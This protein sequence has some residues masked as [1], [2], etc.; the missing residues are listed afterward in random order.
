MRIPALIIIALCGAVGVDAQDLR[1]TITLGAGTAPAVGVIVE[2]TPVA[3]GAPVARTLTNGQGYFAIRL[4]ADVPVTV[5]ALRIGNRPTPLGTF[6]LA[7]G[8]QRSER[9][10]LTGA[11]VVL[12]RV[13]VV[14]ER[15]CR[16]DGEDA[17]ELLTLFDEAR[18][19]ITSTQLAGAT[20]RMTAEWSVQTQVASLRGVALGEPTVR[21]FRAPS[22]SPFVSISPDSLA[23]VGYLEADGETWTYHAPDARV[24][25][26]D[27]FV[28]QNCFRAVPWE[29]DST[30]DWVGISFAPAGRPARGRVRIAG[31]L[32]IDRPTAELRR[33][34]YEYVSLPREITGTPAGGTVEFLRL[35]TGAWLV[36]R[37][38]IRMPR[39][40]TYVDHGVAGLNIGGGTRSTQTTRTT[41]ITSMEV[42]SG[43]ILEVRRA[44][45]VVYRAE[46]EAARAGANANVA[47]LC[48]APDGAPQ[49]MLWGTLRTAGGAPIADAHV[50]AEWQ[51]GHRYYSALNRE[52][53]TARRATR[54][55]ANG[56]WF[57]C[58]VPTDR[59][60]QLTHDL[61]AASAAPLIVRVASAAE[62]VEVVIGSSAPEPRGGTIEGV[63]VDSLGGALPWANAEVAILGSARRATTDGAGNFRL[64]N[65]PVGRHELTIIDPRAGF[66]DLTAPTVVAVVAADGQTVRLTMASASPAAQFRALCDRAPSPGEGVLL[67]EIRDATGARREGVVVTGDWSTSLIGSG[68]SERTMHAVSDTTAADGRYRL[69]GVPVEGEVSGGGGG[70]ATLVSGEVSLRASGPDLAS[71]EVIARLDGAA[72]ARRDLVVG[73]ERRTSALSGRVLDLLGQPVADATVLVVGR[74]DLSARSDARG[75]WRIDGVPIAS[76]QVMIRA[77]RFLPRVLDLDPRNGRMAV[78]DVKLERIPQQLAQ[79][80]ISGRA[81]G[82]GRAAFE[83][84]RKAGV[85]TFLD[86][87]WVARM[88]VV[89]PASV[90]AQIPKSRL[91]QDP[92]PGYH[93]YYK[94]G[95]E[96]DID[97]GG[98]TDT[99]FGAM[100]TCF[101]RWFV[102]GAPY[103]IPTGAEEMQLLAQA[104]RIEVYR[105]AEAPSGYIDFNGC[106][107]VVIS[108][109][110]A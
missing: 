102:D 51:H 19:A 8:E 40:T 60:V 103:G 39:P 25:T 70:A 88:P 99:A 53:E 55:A 109:Y 97:Q 7:A 76:I 84:R 83:E 90:R 105:A 62:P 34:E 58:D 29:A 71:G 38:S 89:T 3:G 14:G 82:P 23:K 110:D 22:E 87:A 54:S 36:N 27:Q 100:K 73:S 31:V 69:C 72:V 67:G 16:L 47:A 33:L 94:I 61:E 28:Q 63:V 75:A 10:A 26:S 95:F 78:G 2:A 49:A 48:A 81:V 66:F 68:L 24:L 59:P 35:S 9:F 41:R 30:R 64:R 80:I 37:W 44:G 5:R 65:V 11:A 6:A 52:W 12:D 56:L 50:Q 107:S 104:K 86:E 13:A 18:K 45:A 42:A 43:R 96:T 4:P 85:G 15:T 98:G 1:G 92:T 57:L 46:P 101:P 91:V 74:S 79:M 106:G 77:I 21:T 17:R 32:W 20:G 108:T 93:N